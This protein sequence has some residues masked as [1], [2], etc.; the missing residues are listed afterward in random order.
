MRRYRGRN[1]C[2]LGLLLGIVCAFDLGCV[3][4]GTELLLEESTD[5]GEPTCDDEVCGCE[6]GV[7]NGNDAGGNASC[8]ITDGVVCISACQREIGSPCTENIECASGFCCPNDYTCR[9]DEGLDCAA[10]QLCASTLLSPECVNPGCGNN[11]LE[12]GEACDDGNLADD[13]GCA[14]V[15]TVEDG[16]FC[17][18]EPSQCE[19]C[20]AGYAYSAADGACLDIDECATGNGGCDL[21]AQCMNTPGGRSCSCDWGYHG[22]GTVC[23]ID[24]LDCGFVLAAFQGSPSGIY[25]IDPDGDQAIAGNKPPFFTYCDMTTD[26]SWTLVLKADGTKS[27]FTYDSELWVNT[28]ALNPDSYAWDLTEAKL[29]SYALVPFTDVRITMVDGGIPRSIT[30]AQESSSMH[31][32]LS[33]GRYTATTLLRDEWKNLM[34]TGSLQVNCNLQGFNAVAGSVAA[35]IGIIANNETNCN[36]PDSFIGVGIR[37]ACGVCPAS[38]SVG[39]FSSSISPDNGA[40][41]TAGFAYVS[42]RRSV[43]PPTSIHYAQTLAVYT[44]FDICP[45]IP[46]VDGPP[47]NYSSDLPLPAG[48]TLDRVTGVI[49]GHLATLLPSARNVTIKADNPLGEVATSLSIESAPAENLRSCNEIKAAHPN[50]SDGAYMIDPDS[51]GPN[52]PF[53]TYCDMTT[54]G[55]G[56]TLALKIDGT[57]STFAYAASP[58]TTTV[59]L[60]QDEVCFDSVEA[61]LPSYSTVPF[62][63]VLV[64]VLD[65]GVL[66]KLVIPQAATSLFDLLKDGV[67]TPSSVSSGAWRGLMAS[68]SLQPGCQ[69][70]GFNVVSAFVSVRIGMLGNELSDPGVCNTADSFIGIGTTTANTAIAA[71]NYTSDYDYDNGFRNT[72]VMGYVFVR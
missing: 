53:K 47:N 72:A 7:L 71:G 67:Y 46:S 37:P 54:D 33:A 62:S 22:D 2:L 63:Q 36:S 58:W 35:R 15:C 68:S 38:M 65:A 30:V 23:A 5:N 16:W 11:V 49:S 64:R 28:T 45:V 40:V 29:A 1:S 57:K 27:T 3:R 55:G 66:R 6:A 41:T 39:D 51:T 44:S 60:N 14:A 24:L 50:F 17:R 19:T 18:N 43:T 20:G 8:D 31:A 70:G 9:C 52:P 42:V 61:K 56:W 25:E 32:L 26:G 10:G 4:M 12:P 48:L 69:Q 59:T 21:N 13:D 34:A